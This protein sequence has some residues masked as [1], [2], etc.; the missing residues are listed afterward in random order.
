MSEHGLT[1][2]MLAAIRGDETL[3]KV[4]LDAGAD[5]DAETPTIAGAQNHPGAYPNPET[6]HWTALTYC[7]IQG[8]LN[9]AKLLLDRGA[10]VEGGAR[11][12]EEKCTETPLQVYFILSSMICRIK[13]N[14]VFTGGCWF[15]KSG[16]DFAIVGSRSKTIPFYAD[17]GYI[18]LFKFRP[19]R[20]LQV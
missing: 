17:A 14:I 19:E 9:I 1:P 3:A 13:E 11:L 18:M 16:H 12:S 6:Q 5:V 10:N 4:L 8:Q 2:L 7:A 20:M 15:G